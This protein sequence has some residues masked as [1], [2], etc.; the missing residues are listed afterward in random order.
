VLYSVAN[1]LNTGPVV[2]SL[3]KIYPLDK[4]S[5]GSMLRAVGIN[6]VL[7]KRPLKVGFIHKFATL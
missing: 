6:D 1:I 2:Q 7:V 4:C 5:Q 3:D